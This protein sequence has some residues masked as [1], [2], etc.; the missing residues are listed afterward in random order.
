LWL[1]NLLGR[2]LLVNLSRDRDLTLDWWLRNP[3]L[4]RRASLK[5]LLRRDLLVDL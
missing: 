2:N 1:K 4:Q 5:D 3:S